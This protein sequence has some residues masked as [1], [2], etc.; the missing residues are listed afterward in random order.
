MSYSVLSDDAAST[1]RARLWQL[2]ESQWPQVDEHSIPAPLVVLDKARYVVGGLAF[3]QAIPPNS[4]QPATWINAV[5]I[6]PAHRNQGLATQLIQ[7]AEQAA[8]QLNLRE[9]FVLTH[10]PTLYGALGWQT[11]S[12]DGDDTVLKKCLAAK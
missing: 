8:I 3:T 7:A 5:Y 2:F 6:S 12:T 9:L 4:A 11:V 10:R 1:Y